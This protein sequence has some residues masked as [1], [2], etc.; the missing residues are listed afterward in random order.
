MTRPVFTVDDLLTRAASGRPDHTALVDGDR[1]LSF[2]ALDRQVGLLAARLIGDG[3]RRGERVAIWLERSMESVVAMLA[4][5]RAGG[6]FVNVSPVLR[7]PQVSHILTDSGAARLIGDP[8]VLGG[9]SLPSMPLAYVTGEDPVEL[10]FAAKVEPLGSLP[11]REEPGRAMLESPL[12]IEGDPATILYT[13][14]STGMPKGIMFSHRNLVA[15][16]QIVSTYLGNGP[17]D[18]VLAVLPFSFDYGLSQVTTMLR[19]AGTVVIQRSLMPGDILETLR[20]ERVTGLAM[21]PPLWPVVLQN[22]RSM[23]DQP[24]PD[25]RYV[26]NSGGAVA[27]AHLEEMRNLLPDTKIFLMY[28]LTEAFRSTFLPPD[29][30]HRGPSCIG[31]AIPGTDIFVVDEEGREVAPGEVGELVHRG[32]TVAMGY[33]GDPERTA[34][35][36]KSNPFAPEELSH[37]DRV[38]YS[39]D[40]VRR[41][42]DGFLYFVGRRDAQIKTHGYRVSPEEAEA[43]LLA[44]PGVREAV[45]FPEPDE[46]I[47]QRIVAVVTLWD[48]ASLSPDVVRATVRRQAPHY[49]VPSRVEIA[50]SLPRGATGKLD[51]EGIARSYGARG[52]EPSGRIA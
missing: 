29:E 22:R 36:Y 32:P 51:R 50:D 39:G 15:G 18:R 34:R 42:E 20:K 37:I 26:T 1:S 12:A 48:G 41:G 40:L 45:V 52:D 21:V 8:V 44:V 2:A 13:S 23:Q 38:V 16:A 49:L 9:A 33:W 10:P 4:V 11:L 27:R 35:C 25:L 14:G 6:V 47:G 46:N 7:A 43:L 31:R 5:A 3:L 30:V 28:G 19:V 17:D 24:L